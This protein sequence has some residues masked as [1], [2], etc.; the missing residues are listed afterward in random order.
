MGVA[1]VGVR[2]G[3]EV[4]GA[5][6]GTKPRELKALE[7]EGA[8]A[9]LTEGERRLAAHER[10]QGLHSVHHDTDGKAAAAHAGN[11]RQF[12]IEFARIAHQR[13]NEP[14]TP[15]LPLTLG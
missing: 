11:T 6:I 15:M 8:E 5:A 7:V 13:F 2:L 1:G 10:L 12:L 3:V 14:K 9:A 4:G